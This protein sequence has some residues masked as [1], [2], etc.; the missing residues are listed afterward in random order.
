MLR[1]LLITLFCLS[2]SG[3]SHTQ[4]QTRFHSLCNQACKAMEDGMLDHAYVLLTEAFALNIKAR[5]ADYLNMAKC[6]SQ[7]NEPDSTEKYIRLALDRNPKIRPAVRIHSLWF[8]PVLGEEKWSKIVVST[9]EKIAIPK[10]VEAIAEE[11]GNLQS[12][13]RQI[14][15]RY[16]RSIDPLVPFDSSRY[17]QYWNSIHLITDQYAPALDSIL[18]NTPIEILTHHVVE[19]SFLLL[20]SYIKKD[21]FSERKEMFD[22]LIG[23]GFMSPDLMNELYLREYFG[24][25]QIAFWNYSPE[26][27]EFY[28]KYGVVF[29][30]YMY[31]FR[32]LNYWK[33][34][35][36]EE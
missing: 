20:R 17:R 8:E 30:T 12:R 9:H 21:Y 36:K 10:E 23:S 19:E 31:N 5:A 34:D 32:I 1:S 14:Q 25:Q 2:V 22:Q 11:I 27:F 7:M 29:D 18:K 28:D 16:N 15:L 4:T 33:Y 6:Y 35:E 26:Y 13:Y 24:D 3:Y